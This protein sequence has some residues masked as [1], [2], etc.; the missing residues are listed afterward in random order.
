MTCSRRLPSCRISPTRR[1]R[2]RRCSTSCSRHEPPTRI[3]DRRQP[4]P[5]RGGH[6]A[7]DDRRRLPRVQ[8]EHRPSVRPDLRRQGGATERREAR[9]GQRGARGRLPRRPRRGHQADRRRRQERRARQPEARQDGR[10][11][12]ERDDDPCPS[13][14]RTGTAIRADHTGHVRQD[15]RGRRHDPAREHLGVARPR[16]HLCRLPG[17]DARR[18][19]GGDD[20]L[21]RRVRR[22]RRRAERGDRVS[23]PVLHAPDAGDGEPLG[24]ADGPRPVLPRARPCVRRGGAGRAGAGRCVH[25]HGRHV[26]GVR[27]GAR[28]APPDDREVA[29]DSRRL[30]PVA[31]CAAPVPRGLRRP[32]GT[33]APGGPG[34]PA[35]AARDQRCVQG[36]HADSAAD[37]RAQREP[38]GQLPRAR[39]PVPGARHDPRAARH[40]DR[41]RRGPAGDHVHRAVP[42]GL[43]LHGLL[44]ASARRAPVAGP[45]RADGR[46]HRAVPGREAGQPEPAEQLRHDAQLAAGRH[47][48]GQEPDR[49]DG[50]ARATR[51]TGSTAPARIRPR[52]TRRGTPTAT[53]RT[54]AT[55]RGR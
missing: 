36:R 9:E 26:R 43:Q 14:L 35:V 40:P 48:A 19:A 22:T 42:D 51:C 2:Q 39:R 21:R 3:I 4:G 20:G 1:R 8:R 25:A 52:S 15:A 24:P 28:G 31:P 6:A 50:R 54:S 16:G 27:A 33:P 34:A 44:P 7:R 10:A 53:P 23:Q 47:R 45:E 49:R 55:S 11:A 30:D 13:A 29:A 37:G 32:L 17:Q 5:D 12:D 46:R 38:R 18:R 41:A